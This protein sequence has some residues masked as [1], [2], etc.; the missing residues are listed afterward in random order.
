MVATTAA[1]APAGKKPRD[2][3][4]K[5]LSPG[6]YRFSRSVMYTRKGV[7][8]FV[9]KTTPKT[10]KP[11]KALTVVKPIGGDKNGGSRVVLLKKRPNYYP[12]AAAIRKNY[13]KSKKQ[14]KVYTRPS[15][16]PGTIC[17]VLAGRHAGKRVVLLKV[18]KSGLA[19]VNGPFHINGCPLRRVHP[20]FLIAT[21]TELDISTLQVPEK[22]NDDY[23]KRKREKRAKKEE[24][25]IFAKKA[26][27]YTPSEERKKDQEAI[28]KQMLQIL[29]KHPERKVMANYLRTMFGLKT[30]QYPHRMKF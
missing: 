26:E 5:E 12:T 20:N 18:L 25:E 13:F 6:V 3:G 27:K 16:T 24:G 21:S 11:K 1:K 17:I 19:L 7:G 15:L 28:D 10:V 4:Q 22:L 14:H 9:K 30:S 2:R 29:K 8:K 23:F